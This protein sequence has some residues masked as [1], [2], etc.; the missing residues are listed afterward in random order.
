MS[1]KPYSRSLGDAPMLHFIVDRL[2]DNVDKNYYIS[3]L[4]PRLKDGL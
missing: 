2:F 1:Y 3:T 4:I